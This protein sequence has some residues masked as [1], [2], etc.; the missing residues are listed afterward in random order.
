M[1]RT[2]PLTHLPQCAG[3]AE[4]RLCDPVNAQETARRSLYLS[5]LEGWPSSGYRPD[6]EAPRIC[7][8]IFPDP[9]PE[10]DPAP[11]NAGQ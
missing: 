9:P 3:Q 5:S 6:P 10:P 2:C 8:L 4:E 7:P 1:R 11:A